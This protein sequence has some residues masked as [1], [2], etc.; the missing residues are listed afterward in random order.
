MTKRPTN[1]LRRFG[2]AL[3]GVITALWLLF[4]GSDGWPWLTS[5]VIVVLLFTLAVPAAL[6]PVQALLTKVGHGVS[7]VVNPAL[8]GLVYF[9]IITPMAW[10]MRQFGYDSMRRERSRNA[11]SYREPSDDTATHRFDRPF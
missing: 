10:M 8:L 2:Y 3:A 9:V 1:E 7:K 4:G 6:G 5:V 11:E